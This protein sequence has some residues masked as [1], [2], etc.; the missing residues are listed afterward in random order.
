[1]SVDV[2][3][4]ESGDVELMDLGAIHVTQCS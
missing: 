1:M 3:L 2:Q 4:F